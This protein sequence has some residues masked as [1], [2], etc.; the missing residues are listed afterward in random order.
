MITMQK[1]VHIQAI[2]ITSRMELR[3][4]SEIWTQAIGAIP[5]DP[6]AALSVPTCGLGGTW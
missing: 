4:Q 1:P 6:S 2:T 3:L 5:T